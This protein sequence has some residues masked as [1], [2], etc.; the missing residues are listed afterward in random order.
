[1]ALSGRWASVLATDY[2]SFNCT[3]LKYP[4]PWLVLGHTYAINRNTKE[5][6]NSN[7]V[8]TPH[9]GY[10][11]QF[12]F[13]LMLALLHRDSCCLLSVCD[14]KVT[15]KNIADFVFRGLQTTYKILS[16][17]HKQTKGTMSKDKISY[18]Q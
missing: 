13:I 9:F 11:L 5:K 16:F 3:S 18:H 10:L 17:I 4:L 15:Y 8:P 12:C 6:V 2:F 1:M 7:V 14:R